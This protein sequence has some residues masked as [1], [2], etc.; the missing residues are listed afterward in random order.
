MGFQFTVLSS[1]SILIAGIISLI[2]FKKINKSYYPFIITIILAC[3][4]E[5]LSDYLIKTG[6]SNSINGN[7]YVC[8]ESLLILFQFRNWGSFNNRK[9]LF[10]YLF[11]LFIGVWIAENFF[12]SKIIYIN[13]YFRITYS[14]ILVLLGIN[15]INEIIIRDR[16][17]I[18]INP[19]FLICIAIVFYFT[20]K[21]LLEVF[22]LYGVNKSDN[23]R[24]S[25]YE[26]HAW[27][28]LFSNLIYALAVIWM[29][30]KQRFLLPS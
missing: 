12:I 25:V 10:W 2:R 3:I 20:Y 14:F 17:N 19:V 21:V 13:S 16:K 8:I 6:K 15:Q 9:Y 27:I 23:F 5:I 11:Y 28:N 7:V 22:W 30:K 26:I 4:N 18:I 1:F 24:T 29:P